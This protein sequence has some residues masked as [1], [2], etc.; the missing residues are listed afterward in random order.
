MSTPTPAPLPVTR[1]AFAVA[2]AG[3]L[4]PRVSRAQPKDDDPPVS[5]TANPTLAP[6]DRL[7]T[8]FIR[9]HAVPGAALAV[10]RGGKLVYARG[11]GS[12]DV[13]KKTPVRP[14]ALFRIA[15]VSKP[16]TAV[17][18]MR[19]IEKKKF[20]LDDKVTDLMGL[21]AVVGRGDT[22]DERWKA[23]TVRHCLQHS[24]GWDRDKSFEPITRPVQIAKAV[25]KKGPSATPTDVVRY[26]MGQP[27]DFD[28]GEKG[29]YSNLG[30]L[31]LGRIIAATTGG[32]Y[33]D[34][35]R[36][37]VFGRIGVTAPRL[38][39]ALPEKRAAG[40]VRYYDSKKRTNWC[41]YPPRLDRKV[42]LPDGG[43]NFEAFEA[44][45]GWIAS[46]VDLVKFAAAFD[47]PAKS[48]LLGAAAIADMWARPAHADTNGWHIGGGWF[49]RPV[50]DGGKA[51]VWH[52]GYIAGTEAVLVRRWD[53]TD[54]AVLFNTNDGAGGKS[55][56]GLIDRP[57]HEAADAV[58]A[59]PD[60]DQFP[61]YLK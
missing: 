9:D 54:W 15:S 19:L 44:H 53:G 45:G 21:K 34:F 23:I 10:S 5:G 6:F 42:P 38:G 24:G 26:M 17:A 57:L 8:G 2:A 30:Y 25:G 49:V 40:E 20:K 31:V 58:T 37:E 46:A 27:L 16:I 29:V 55:L 56:A 13:D 60:G 50:G 4:F 59:W 51:N 1:R 18:V 61:T 35:V 48:P 39:R 47:D 14:D 28:P 7:M 22:A 41:L 43:E 33:E 11:F 36:K 32:T 52:F 3:L 12:A